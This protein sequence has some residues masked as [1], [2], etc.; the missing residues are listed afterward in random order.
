[1]SGKKF[2]VIV[3]GGGV[4]GCTSAY[5]LARAGLKVALV[6][7]ARLAGGT[8]GASFAWI[9]ATSKT[10]DEAYHRLNALGLAG[11]GELAAEF[12]D[13]ALGINPGGALKVVRRGDGDA[14][15]AARA[16]AERLAGWGYPA[17]WLDAAALR[18][19]EPNLSLPDDAEALYSLADLN[20]DAPR[21][22]RFMAARVRALG[23]VVLERCAARSLDAGEDG[24]V[25]GLLTDAGALQ[26]SQVL[27]AAGPGTPEVLSELTGYDGF[28]A[29]FPLRR[30][31][32]LL[33]TTPDLGAR[34]LARHVVYFGGPPEFHLLPD[35]GGGL[36]LGADDTDGMI[37]EDGSLE[38]Q[39]AAARILLD[40]AAERLPGFAGAALLDD[41]RL[42]I[43]VR[44]YPADGVS[45]AGPLP[46][47][48]GLYVIATHSGITLAPALGRLIAETIST[49]RTP[50]ALAPFR[51]ERIEG[52]S[53]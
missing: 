52:L 16:Q 38:S 34:R 45:L 11:Y 40:R 7:R 51:L 17:A 10:G 33:V 26:A 39:R 28:A 29:R 41:C 14:H 42:A 4:I 48:A 50:E 25:R 8:T 35:F 47:A 31:P 13:A 18:A 36:K 6:E 22:A 53:G 12:G 44:P 2:D 24:R 49:G 30:V 23:G 19:L 27:L 1:M 37:A 9:N 43:G 20:L 15:G 46:G 3:V 21:F 32:G 5:F